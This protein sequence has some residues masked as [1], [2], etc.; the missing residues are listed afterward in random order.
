M[1]NIHD[2]C[3]VNI[4]H[5]KW[6]YFPKE[7]LYSYNYCTT[8]HAAGTILKDASSLMNQTLRGSVWALK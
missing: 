6:L 8:V 1:W 7:M 5:L 4:L 2:D 3:E